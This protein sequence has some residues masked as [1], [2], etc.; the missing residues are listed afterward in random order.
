MEEEE[1]R[2]IG[3]MIG[4]RVKEPERKDLGENIKERVAELLEE[5]PLYRGSEVEF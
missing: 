1:L 4:R 5:Y 2:E 3:E